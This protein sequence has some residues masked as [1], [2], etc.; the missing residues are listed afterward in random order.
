MTNTSAATAERKISNHKPSRGA[1]LLFQGRYISRR[2][3][4][5]T[6]WYNPLTDKQMDKQT[7]KQMESEKYL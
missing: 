7:D 6:S 1:G 5:L 3:D 4:Y 2:T